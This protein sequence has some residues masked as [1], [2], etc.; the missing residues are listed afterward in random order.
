MIARLGQSDWR[1]WLPERLI[2]LLLG[3]S[4]L[5]FALWQQPPASLVLLV[6]AAVLAWIRLEIAI[7]LVPLTLP[8]YL[9]L[10]PLRSGG[11]LSFSVGELAIL[12]CFAVAVLRSVIIAADR[13]ETLAWL[14]SLWQQARLFLL[15]GALLLVGASLALLGSPDLH[16]GLRAYR[17]EIVEPLL[18]F[19]LVLRYLRTRA[20]LVRVVVALLL[21]GLIASGTAIIQGLQYL[22]QHASLI[23]SATSTFRPSGPYGSPNNLALLLDR[24]IPMLL[25]IGLT[26]FL[27]PSTAP[28]GA[29]RPIWRDPL[30]WACVLALIP[31]AWALYWSR[32]RGGELAMVAVILFFFIVEVRQWIAIAAVFVAGLVGGVIFHSKL[33]DLLDTGHNG[34][35]T[36]SERLTYWKA[37]LLIIRDH[38]LLGTG[39][40]SFRVLYNPDAPNRPT[41]PNSYALKALDGQAFPKTYDPAIAHPHNFFFDFWISTGLLGL[42]ALFWLLGVCAIVLVRVYRLCGTMSKGDLLQRFVLGIAGCMVGALV[43]GLED[44]FYFVPDLSVLFWLL[45]A[46]LLILTGISQRE[47]GLPQQAKP[48]YPVDTTAA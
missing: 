6:C 18:Y 46:I 27:R 26:H 15:P 42:A 30:R 24:V 40:D 4:M 20:D 3:L 22:T 38:F 13:R 23:N 14:R 25:A 9:D 2:E 12:I 10:E 5:L 32:S 17:Q 11:S 19:L 37:A 48:S 47:Q 31:L 41:S 16:D 29:T 21:T 36:V 28:D 33:L 34:T 39:T 35:V 7:A 43:H 1:S 45:I 44:N 8:Y